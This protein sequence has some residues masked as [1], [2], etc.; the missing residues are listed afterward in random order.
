MCS[1][2]LYGLPAVNSTFTRPKSHNAPPPPSPSSNITASFPQNSCQNTF[3]KLANFFERNQHFT[4][5]GS[6]S[7]RYTEKIASIR[8]QD[9]ASSR[10]QDFLAFTT[11]PPPPTSSSL[12][13]YHCLL[14]CFVKWTF[15]AWVFSSV[16]S[17]SCFVFTFKDLATNSTAFVFWF[18]S[19]VPFLLGPFY[20]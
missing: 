14:G 6:I 20:T 9:I 8:D 15:F 1:H 2:T 5:S 18:L 19:A 17:R 16:I 4:C 11:W 12:C 13:M 3:P 10:N 7:T